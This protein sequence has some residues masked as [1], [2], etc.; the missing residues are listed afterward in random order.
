MW[1]DSCPFM[2]PSPEEML[3]EAARLHQAR[4]YNKCMKTAEKARSKF[5]KEGRLDRAIEA[6]RVMADCALNAHN[7]KKARS[8]YEDLLDEGRKMPNL[9]YQSAAHWGLGQILLRSLSYEEAA[10][11]FETGLDYAKQ[12]ADNWYTAWN[13]FGLANAKR[14]MGRVEDSKSLLQESLS[15]FK[16]ANQAT[17]VAWVTKAIEEVGGEASATSEDIRIWLCPLCGS[18]FSASQVDSLKARK[19]VTCEYCGTTAG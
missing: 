8:L 16:T 17:Y 12:I 19:I 14:A 5:R 11:H 15:A 6:L 10:Q 2:S 13:A 1:I 7:L 18:K 3:Q 9:W 4:N